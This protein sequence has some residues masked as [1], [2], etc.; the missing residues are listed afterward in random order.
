[1][2]LDGWA[3]TC[4]GPVRSYDIDPPSP[5]PAGCLIQAIKN[6][7]AL[8]PAHL[9]KQTYKIVAAVRRADRVRFERLARRKNLRSASLFSEP[10]GRREPCVACGKHIN[11]VHAHHS[12]P[13]S[14]Q[15]ECGMDE[16]IHDY[17]W[18]C[19]VHHKR[20][21]IL[22]SGYLLGSRDLC[23]LEGIP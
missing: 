21:H 1:V 6:L 12:F 4:S 7:P 13:L 19:P 3:Q 9:C 16:P 22:L 5:G 11:F 10:T 2:T 15:F 20:V 14:L 18:L 23:F 8:I 17:Q